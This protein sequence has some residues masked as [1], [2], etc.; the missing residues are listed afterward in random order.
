ME[1]EGFKVKGGK[2]RGVDVSSI[3]FSY[4]H[5][6]QCPKCAANGRD[7]SHNNF[8]VYDPDG[9]GRP[10]GGICYGA[11]CG[12]RVLSAQVLEELREGG[13]TG[14]MSEEDRLEL[15]AQQILNKSKRSQE[16]ALGKALSLTE[17]KAIWTSTGEDPKGWRG[18]T[19]ET[20]NELK[21][22]FRYD[23][24]TGEPSSMLVPVFMPKDAGA[25]P[26]V[27]GYKVRVFPKDFTQS[28]GAF[29][30]ATD[31]IGMHKF[32]SHNKTLLIFGGECYTPDTEVMTGR[33]FV[34]FAELTKDDL[35]LQ[36]NTDGS[37]NLVK[38][39]RYIEKDYEGLVYE[40]SGSKFSFSTT[41]NHK[42]V[43]KNSRGDFT[44]KLAKDYVPATH[45][46][47][48]NTELAGKGIGLSEDQIIFKIALCADAKI[49]VRSTGKFAHFAFKKVR[50]IER[51]RG[52]L[53]RLGLEYSSYEKTWSNDDYTTFNVK[54][55]EYADDKVI[56]VEWISNATILEK[57]F[58]I[59][60]L[61]LWDGNFEKTHYEYTTIAFSSKYFSEASTVQGLAATAG[62]YSTLRKRSNKFGTWYVVLI[63]DK[64]RHHEAT[65]QNMR[66]GSRQYSGK[67]Y[68]VT[69]DSGMILVRRD[70]KVGVCGNCDWA[71]A[72]QMYKSKKPEK[73]IPAMV[74][75]TLGEAGTLSHFLENQR[76][77]DFFTQFEKV[78]LVLDSD[79]AGMKAMDDFAEK[80]PREKLHRVQLRYKDPNEYLQKGKIQEFIDDV[81]FKAKPCHESLILG[82]GNWQ[83][84][85]NV[86]VSVEKLSLPPF[87]A[88]LQKALKGGFPMGRI[89]TIG[90]SS[91][92]GK[93]T[94]VNSMIYY[95]LSLQSHKVGIVSLE[96]TFGQYCMDMLSRHV[97]RKIDA[98]ET[99]AE[100]QEF[101]ARPDVVS[102]GDAF[103]YNQDGTDR[104]HVVDNRDSNIEEIQKLCEQMVI[105]NGV[106]VLIL[107]P[108]SD[109]TQKLDR[110]KQV[111]FAAWQKN[112]V[113]KHNVLMIQ[114]SHVR[115]SGNG[116]KSYAEGA[117]PT[118][119]DLIGSY[120]VGSSSACT[121]MLARD[122]MS[123]NDRTRNTTGIYVPKCRWSA[124]T[125][126]LD[127]IF[128]D[129]SS[130]RLHNLE[131]WD[132][133]IIEEGPRLLPHES[134]DMDGE[135][136]DT[137]SA[138]EDQYQKDR[139]KKLSGNHVMVDF[140]DF[141]DDD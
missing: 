11:D 122:K 62:R 25:K 118:E 60:E 3:D 22:R 80:M 28:V 83:E 65:T 129:I 121:L 35:V 128:Y 49:D 56:P 114:I 110:E 50:K 38:P 132:L 126:H 140:G 113:K 58:I 92:A 135:D 109:L 45:K 138:D 97:G 70:G 69:V 82:S 106:Q 86:E 130:H 53:D 66:Q 18:L 71:S 104:F 46:V 125:G 41:E 85:I 4:E 17:A 26:S 47:V 29:N 37:S 14:S 39:Q 115:K 111:E 74:T 127:D 95:W 91:S 19:R 59:S 2:V 90:A 94:L 61:A 93:T 15:Q 1:Y 81:E 98:M 64:G 101:L 27:V 76:N 108:V 21:I 133:G 23:Q 52:V 124:V 9:L 75:S 89:I 20:C 34:P 13:S 6:E 54:L 31:M 87:L 99:V 107:D 44:T 68:C 100:Q 103:F 30:T 119:D 123:D 8:Q 42:M 102:A 131:Q 16:K 72:Y 24:E 5:K 57:D 32:H 36:V 77:Y 67:V 117:V 63:H 137:Y 48:L 10:S 84:A 105:Q 43:Y 134:L 73:Y 141:E 136:T 12:F 78:V 51:L 55:P 7:R 33:G 88:K 112:F 120:A 79:E 40:N 116:Q 96:L 139:D